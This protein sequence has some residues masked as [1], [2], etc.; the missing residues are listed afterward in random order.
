MTSI[1]TSPSRAALAPLLLSHR[2][3]IGTILGAGAMV[4]IEFT[5][6]V[7]IAS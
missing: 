5:A 3:Q 1:T 4:G 6:V 2:H 7:E